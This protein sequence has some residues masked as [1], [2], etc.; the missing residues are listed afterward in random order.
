M[1]RL[2]DAMPR[3][4]EMPL[5]RC[6]FMPLFSYRDAAAYDDF[7]MLTIFSDAITPLSLLI[8]ATPACCRLISQIDCR[9]R[10]RLRH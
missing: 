1:P 2:R 10:R 9:R 4:I 3:A 6:R 5:L 8:R 7:E